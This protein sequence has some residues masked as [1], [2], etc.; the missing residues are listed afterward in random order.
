[1]SAIF[2]RPKSTFTEY[3]KKIKSLR[4]TLL[5]QWQANAKV[6]AN[7][8]TR[9]S[10]KQFFWWLFLAIPLKTRPTPS[11]DGFKLLE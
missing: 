10:T 8:N 9:E 7:R 6:Q 3:F 11:I 2:V 5:P 4:C 1:M